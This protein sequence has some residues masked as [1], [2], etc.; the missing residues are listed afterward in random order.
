L[1]IFTARV[2]EKGVLEKTERASPYKT[3][4]NGGDHN[5]SMKCVDIKET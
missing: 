3:T 5:N 2:A 4:I 1:K